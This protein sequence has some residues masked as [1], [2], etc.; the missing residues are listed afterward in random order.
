MPC[1]CE[2]R[3]ATVLQV[4]K[5]NILQLM[6]KKW[7]LIIILILPIALFAMGFQ[8]F[9][10]DISS[11]GF[12]WDIAFSDGDDTVLS[13]HLAS[14]LKKEA[15]DFTLVAEQKVNRG[16]LDGIHDAA[17]L[18]PQ[19]W[20][21]AIMQG[22]APKVIVRSLKGMET[23]ATLT[24]VINM[25]IGDMLRLQDIEKMQVPQELADRRDQLDR[26]GMQFSEVP[27]SENMLSPGFN[28]ASRFLLYILSVSMIQVGTL[29]LNEKQQGTLNRIRQTPLCSVAFV[30]ANFLT[31]IL[32]LL[33]N[34]FC[35]WI[36]TTFVFHFKTTFT[37]YFLWLTF[38]MIWILI[39]IYISLS[40]R[41]STFHNTLVSPLT[42]LTAM[43]GGSYWPVWLMPEWMQ[44]LSIITPHYWVND[45]MMEVEKG[46][47][48]LQLP[49]HMLALSAFVLLFLS[50]CI[51]AMRRSKHTESF[52]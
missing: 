26:E 38:G 42:V 22:K 8:L 15:R 10:S 50:L 41:T 35:L 20:E 39:S 48:L 28:V 27:L 31:G 37:M 45:A 36:L 19:G 17:V 34:L 3:E 16:L 46:H 33:F 13:R 7:S 51:F 4:I 43:L 11:G 14:M 9:S 44:R 24:T 52:V 40:V 23:V 1:S 32:F 49:H 47:H 30:V 29:I 5:N 2:R 12:A 21:D 18:V 25:Y 6:A